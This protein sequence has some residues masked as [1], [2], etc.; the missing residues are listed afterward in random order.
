M[1]DDNVYLTIGPRQAGWLVSTL[2]LLIEEYTDK[3]H[4]ERHHED[5]AEACGVVAHAVT[6]LQRLHLG[7]HAREVAAKLPP[8]S[9]L[10]D[11]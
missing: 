4:R 7:L 6:I 2:E 1:T 9:D 11:S 5:K 8:M 3:A 10:T